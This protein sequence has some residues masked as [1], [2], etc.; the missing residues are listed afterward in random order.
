MKERAFYE[1]ARLRFKFDQRIELLAGWFAASMNEGN[2]GIVAR[3]ALWETE[4]GFDS[5]YSLLADD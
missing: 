3:S 1:Q 2:L 4:C 5:G